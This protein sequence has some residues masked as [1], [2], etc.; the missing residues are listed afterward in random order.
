MSKKD[1][2]LR[3]PNGTFRGAPMSIISIPF[4]KPS[5]EALQ[6]GGK[7]A[8]H[9]YLPAKDLVFKPLPGNE[10]KK[11]WPCGFD[12]TPLGT[13]SEFLISSQQRTNTAK[14]KMIHRTKFQ[15]TGQRFSQ[16]RFKQSNTKK[17]MQLHAQEHAGKLKSSNYTRSD[18]VTCTR[19]RDV[20]ILRTHTTVNN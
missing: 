17:N 2:N 16:S 3:S 6:E 8:F 19:T 14:K 7:R 4:V 5:I 10:E 9:K 15:K 13:G 12:R 18:A 11:Y 20:T 1:L